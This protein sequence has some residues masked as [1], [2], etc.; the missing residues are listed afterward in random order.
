MDDDNRRT[1]YEVGYG[2]P[3]RSTRF[4]P[5]QSGN[6][7]GRPKGARGLKAELRAELDEWVTITSDGRSRRIR[8]RRLIVKA[9]AA[10]AAKGDVKAADKLLSMVIQAEGFE[11]QRP[12]H[13]RL[14]ET[15]L[16]MLEQ[17]LGPS[18]ADDS[19][20]AAP[21]PDEPADHENDS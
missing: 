16:L 6:T 14:S 3:P 19:P 7:R 4:A 10:K 15:D 1:D 17:V 11:D 20:V 2:R 9:L 18:P 21:V 13:A 5:G 12:Q 8:K